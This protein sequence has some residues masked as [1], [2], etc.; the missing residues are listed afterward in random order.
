MH[1]NNIKD[2]EYYF[3]DK[4]V[5][6]ADCLKYTLEFIDVALEVYAENQR[7]LP[8]TIRGLGFKNFVVQ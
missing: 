4:T 2:I 5:K 3:Y 6:E 1:I 7:E 8:A